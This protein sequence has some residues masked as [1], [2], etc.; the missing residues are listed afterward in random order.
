MHIH[1][2]IKK[3][4]SKPTNDNKENNLTIEI[5]SYCSHD[6]GLHDGKAF[7]SLITIAT[8]VATSTESTSFP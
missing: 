8:L 4:L 6:R 3:L 1:I 2:K 7:L 5:I